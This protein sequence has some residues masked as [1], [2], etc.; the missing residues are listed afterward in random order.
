MKPPH[1]SYWNTRFN[2]LIPLMAIEPH[3][4]CWDLT[5]TETGIDPDQIITHWPAA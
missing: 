3:L 5:I 1:Y 2:L 4:P